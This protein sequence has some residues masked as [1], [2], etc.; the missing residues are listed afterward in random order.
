MLGF[1][2]IFNLMIMSVCLCSVNKRLDEWVSGDRLDYSKLQFPKKDGKS[3]R[4]TDSRSSSPDREIV[5]VSF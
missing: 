3:R 2:V 1:I 4:G 5:V